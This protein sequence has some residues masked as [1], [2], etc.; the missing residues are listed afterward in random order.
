MCNLKDLAKAHAC[1]GCTQLFCWRCERKMFKE[2]PNGEECAGQARRC[3]ACCNGVSLDLFL[4]VH[5]RK[6][7]E[8]VPPDL[9]ISLVE[10]HIADGRVG[11][12]AELTPFQKCGGVLHVIVT[13]SFQP[14]PSQT[15]SLGPHLSFLHVARLLSR[16]SLSVVLDQ[17][18]IAI[19]LQILLL[20]I[21]GEE[22][23]PG[24]QQAHLGNRIR[25]CHR[26]CRRVASCRCLC[27]QFYD[28][29]V[30][31]RPPDI[32]SEATASC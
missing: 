20:L 9:R 23:A 18:E 7:E 13:R 28:R 31:R 22:T 4:K 11:I 2:C 19:E 1:P 3:V 6:I 17:H 24:G 25:S 21:L 32:W 5:E 8:A 15:T 16:Q 30:V 27:C 12:G 29:M 14:H 10:R 26:N